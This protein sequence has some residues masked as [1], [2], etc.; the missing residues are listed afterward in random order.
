MAETAFRPPPVLDLSG[1]VSDS[2][3]RFKQRFEIYLKA[4]GKDEEKDEKKKVAM[5]LNLIGDEALEVFNTFQFA[6]GTSVDN[7]V[8]VLAKFESYCNPRKNL[9]YEQSKFFTHSQREGE[10][11]DKFLIE[12]RKLAQT[13]EFG[14]KNDQLLTLRVVLG[15]N[16]RVL[17]ERLLRVPDLTLVKAADYCRAAEVSRQQAEEMDATSRTVEPV[18]MKNKKIEKTKKESSPTTLQG[19]S[20]VCVFCGYMHP[21]RKC[22]AYGKKCNGCGGLN[23][24]SKVCFKQSKKKDIQNVDVDEQTGSDDDQGNQMYVSSVQS[25]VPRL[26][27]SQWCTDITVEGSKVNFKLDTG[28]EVSILPYNCFKKLMTSLELQATKIKLVSFGNSIIVPKG[29]V[30]LQCMHGKKKENISF[31]VADVQSKPLLGIVECIQLG[32][33]KRTCEVQVA[34]G[35]TK[36]LVVEQ[37]KDVFSGLGTLPGTYKIEMK[38][39]AIPK[40]QPPR[41][42]PL[43][44]RDKLKE[45]LD[46]ME[47]QG[48]IESVVR[49]TDWVSSVVI[50]EKPNGSLRLC[51]DPI[52]LNSQIKRE[53]Y[54]IPTSEDILSNLSG[55]KVYSV[56][57]MKDSFWQ[58]VLDSSCTDLCTFNTPFGRYK[59]LR[60]PFGLCSS[61]EVFQ[62]MNVGVFGDIEG[63]QVIFDDIIVAGSTQEEHDK[64]L[65]QVLARARSCNVKFNPEKFQ[66]RVDEVRYMGHLMSSRGVRPDPERI[67]A[68]VDM[69]VPT[70][71]EEVR[72]LLGMLNY[73]HQFLPNVSAVLAPLR[74]LLKKETEWHWEHEQVKALQSLKNLLCSA[75]VLAYYDS[76]KPLVLQTDASKDGIGACLVQ[77]GHPVAYASRS[78][79]EAEKNYSQIEKEL[80]AVCFGV[81]KFHYYC[82][83]RSVQVQTDHKPIE[84][85]MRKPV[86]KVSPRLQRMQLKLLRYDLDITYLPGKQ[87]LLADPLSRATL[88]EQGI[89]DEEMDVVVHMVSKHLPMTDQRKQQFRLA[90]ESYDT[91]QV[92]KSLVKTQ[93]P[94]HK[95]LVP[96]CCRYFWDLKD[97]ITE[98]EGLVFIG[99]KVLVPPGL[100]KDML[101]AIHEG[102]MG[103]EKCKARARSVMF[104]PGMCQEIH[105]YVNKCETCQR[106]AKCNAKEPLKPHPVPDR[107]WVTLGTDILE[108]QG[109]TYLVVKDY[110]SK[111]IE[112][113]QIRNKSAAEVINKLQSIFARH[114]VPE[115]L[116]SDNVPFNSLE[117]REFA[118][119]WNFSVT[120]SSPNY[121][122]S[123]GMAEN[124]VKLVKTMLKKASYETQNVYL[125]LL[126]YRNTP[127]SGVGLS[128][129]QMLMSRVLKTKLPTVEALLKPKVC[130]NVKNT[131]QNVQ[132]KQKMFYDRSAVKLPPLG[133]KESVW[134]RKDKVWQPAVVL[135]K[136]VT[137]RSY[138]VETEAGLVLRRNRGDL[139]KSAIRHESQNVR[140][141][142]IL[143]ELPNPVPDSE[144]MVPSADPSD[145][146][147]ECGPTR[148]A[149]TVP[150]CNPT[151][152][153]RTGRVINRPVRFKDYV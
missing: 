33:V 113:V 64:A 7:L 121:P 95:Y 28:S 73:V 135:N 92:L 25:K 29:V 20:K 143:A 111:W 76:K 39:N 90:T 13:C 46:I 96:N 124:A 30:C 37:Y 5:L 42:V 144:T 77:N 148:H 114:G 18:R 118:E 6:A 120:T 23:H 150:A 119:S 62:R 141:N 98:N 3:K 79:S 66:Y 147:P 72:R 122:K 102:H 146:V 67:R 35:S 53:H 61:P 48:V 57:D 47:K 125:Y 132:L 60:M 1:N 63:V 117:F 109:K 36:E 137:P 8:D 82:Y 110:F 2:W 81:T 4:S 32:L 100:R 40:V 86:N 133:E 85:I 27:P 24:F 103:I 49:P 116:V 145:S 65:V 149:D 123:N 12:L 139:R 91:A 22:P 153:S 54:P 68:I 43:T 71:V 58:V 129:S 9:V 38:D 26:R 93:W 131:L 115:M 126:E 51:I 50:V 104:W 107:A 128:P 55:K 56:L 134:V 74:L 106:F 80:N 69:P 142:P 87:M 151:P 45:T 78:M 75:P 88:A 17:R 138:L 16:D 101:Q 19:E 112:L 21:P 52:D 31:V 15:I 11:F 83:G 140:D 10:P 59:Y 41:R 136:H 14:D 130:K 34:L 127:I 105:D 152:T 84:S 89:V 99:N 44:V 94:S 108:C 97:D 70:S